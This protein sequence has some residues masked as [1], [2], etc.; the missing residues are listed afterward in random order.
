VSIASDGETRRGRALTLLT[1]NC[2]L[3]EGS[4]IYE[5]LAPLWFMNLLTG[6]GD[7]TADKDC[8]HV[9][10]QIRCKELHPSGFAIFDQV[11]TPDAIQLHLS[12]SG[13][14][15]AHIR[16]VFQPNDKQ[17]VL[18]A[19]SALQDVVALPPAAEDKSPGFRSTRDALRILGQ[20]FMY[21]LHPYICI[22]LSLSEQLEYLS[23]AAHLLLLLYRANGNK[24]LSKLLYVDIMI[25]IKNVYFCVAKAKVDNPLGCFFL[26]LLGTDRLE[27][28]FG[29]IHSIVGNDCGVDLL[30]LGERSTGTVEVADILGRKPAWDKPPRRLNMPLID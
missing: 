7:L 25:M 17:D 3:P 13:R 11:L 27:T 6:E 8:K 28:L 9:I 24:F 16:V 14:S 15:K 26:M 1:M 30:Q 5:L 23:A 20:M 10:K 21:L 29:I 22:D 12:E 19:F 18:L 2:R 4:N